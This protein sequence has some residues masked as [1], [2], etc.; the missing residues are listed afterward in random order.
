MT[1]AALDMA[2]I[3]LAGAET[4]QKAIQ[5]AHDFA[6]H[7]MGRHEEA[8]RWVGTLTVVDAHADD[9]DG[10]DDRAHSA[11][12]VEEAQRVD[13]GQLAQDQLDDAEKD[14]KLLQRHAAA[15]LVRLVHD[16][17]VA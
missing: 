6:Q 1:G 11:Q 16:L 3:I 7:A 9:D 17:H 10:E 4:S 2:R 14:D 5:T 13:V 8:L 15:G 12:E